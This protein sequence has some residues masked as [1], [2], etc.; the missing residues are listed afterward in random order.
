MNIK[1][2]NKILLVNVLG[3]SIE[4][5]SIGY[6]KIYKKRFIMRNSLTQL[7]RLRGP[8]CLLQAGSPGKL[9]V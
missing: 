8:P 7:W 2:V 6:K 9:V 4:V 1:Q 5:E 3:F